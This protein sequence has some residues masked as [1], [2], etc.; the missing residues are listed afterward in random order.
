MVTKMAFEGKI[1]SF[2]QDKLDDFTYIDE[3]NMVAE[4]SDNFAIKIV[5]D[6]KGG[7][8]IDDLALLSRAL[9]K[10][11]EKTYPA[12]VYSLELT[13]RGIG[14]PLTADYHWDNSRGRKVKF[15][16]SDSTT[17]KFI[18]TEG[19]IG[20]ILDDDSIEII[21]KSKTGFVV[22]VYNLKDIVEAKIVPDFS[23]PSSDELELSG[24]PPE[25]VSLSNLG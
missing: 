1:I 21:E 6:R 4:G 18:I 2:L 5:I 11:I 17:G 12:V 13:S 10:Y 23:S 22:N 16:Y 8:R 9:D 19:R 7:I 3:L 15:K 25:Y 24:V 20:K 14:A